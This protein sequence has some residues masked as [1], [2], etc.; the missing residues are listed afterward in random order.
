MLPILRARSL[1]NRMSTHGELSTITRIIPPNEFP[2]DAVSAR[3]PRTE[4]FFILLGINK[5][6]STFGEDGEQLNELDLSAIN[7][8]TRPRLIKLIKHSGLVHGE[9]NVPICQYNERFIISDDD[10]TITIIMRMFRFWK[11]WLE[12]GSSTTTCLKRRRNIAARCK[13]K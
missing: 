3:K 2:F 1:T 13:M 10:S 4:T 8:F 7:E 12:S 11:I 6:V 9:L 5:N